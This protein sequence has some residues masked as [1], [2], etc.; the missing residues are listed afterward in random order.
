[1]EKI[2]L[3]LSKPGHYLFKNVWEESRSYILLV[4]VVNEAPL[5]E[6]R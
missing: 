6:I 1:M 2:N 3:V 5:H 4:L